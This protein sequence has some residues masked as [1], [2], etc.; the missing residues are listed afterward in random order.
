M[1]QIVS[2]YAVEVNVVKV[3]TS[4]IYV[5]LWLGAKN[6]FDLC[7]ILSDSGKPVV[8]VCKSNRT[9]MG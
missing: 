5:C 6:N 9:K 1:R 7:H 2:R 3:L 8:V 4:L